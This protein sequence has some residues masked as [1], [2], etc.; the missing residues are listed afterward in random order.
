MHIL[1]INDQ[2]SVLME[3]EVPWLSEIMCIIPQRIELRSQFS[4]TFCE[5]VH[6][7]V[8]YVSKFLRRPQHFIE[9][10]VF[11][12]VYEATESLPQVLRISQTFSCVRYL[13]LDRPSQQTFDYFAHTE[14]S[15][16]NI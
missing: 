11:K 3:N 13:S 6:Y 8:D 16:V 5:L 9:A 2:I 4:L 15:E 10:L 14:E 1:S 12:L 7:I